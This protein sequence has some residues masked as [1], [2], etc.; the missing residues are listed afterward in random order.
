MKFKTY[1]LTIK[2]NI[3]EDKP[4]FIREEIIT[5]DDDVVVIEVDDIEDLS[6]HDI[7][8]ITDIGIT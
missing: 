2:Y 3:K 6:I 4:E 5:D 7:D 1:I 8:G